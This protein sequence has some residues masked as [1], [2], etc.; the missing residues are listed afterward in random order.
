METTVV[1]P[2]GFELKG[3]SPE[4]LSA[5]VV[6]EGIGVLLARFPRLVHIK[7]HAEEREI[8][9]RS[10]GAASFT[11][12]DMVDRR[13]L[14]PVDPNPVEVPLRL[15]AAPSMRDQVVEHISRYLSARAQ[16]EGFESLEEAM[17]FDIEGELDDLQTRAEG[18]Y[19]ASFAPHEGR[20][21]NAPGLKRDERPE[22]KKPE[23]TL[24][25]PIVPAPAAAEKPRPST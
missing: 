10:D 25:E 3:V 12:F 17:D 24:E 5:F 4:I 8:L 14:E 20:A 15:K 22:N 7:P 13:G 11:T 16:D 19:L 18:A 9:F 2:A 21:N 6:V 1:L 23:M